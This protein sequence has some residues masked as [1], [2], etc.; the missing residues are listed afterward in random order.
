MRADMSI[1]MLKQNVS[2][3]TLELLEQFVN[4]L[5]KWNAKINL[6]SKYLS[7]DLIWREH[8]FDS[9]LLSLYMEKKN[10]R[11]VDLGSG[12]GFPGIILSIMGYQDCNLVEINAKKCSFL[13]YVVATLNLNARVYGVD[14][15]HIMLEGVDYI[16]SRAVASI[17]GVI[18]MTRH[19]LQDKTK[20]L[21]H[22]GTNHIDSELNILRLHYSF[23]L[24]EWSNPYKDNC[25]V[26]LITDIKRNCHLKVM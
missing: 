22:V 13:N 24:Q 15:N 26:V 1:L 17:N 12:A 25:S 18:N 4:I 7:E 11:I 19:L 6:V 16:T 21:L 8:V 14:V 20:Y 5:I 2:R 3:E 9:M 10:L 23:K